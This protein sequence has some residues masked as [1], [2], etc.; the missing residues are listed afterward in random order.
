MGF[1]QRSVPMMSVGSGAG[2]RSVAA[3]VG[4]AATD[5]D[6]AGGGVGATG[7]GGGDP[8]PIGPR[9]TANTPAETERI[10]RRINAVIQARA[11]RVD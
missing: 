2:D 7:G 11:G 6:G 3:G 4:S 10:G 8:H 5:A 1:F 9:I